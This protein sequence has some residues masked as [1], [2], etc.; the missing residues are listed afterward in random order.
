MKASLLALVLSLLFYCSYSEAYEQQYQVGGV[1]PNGGTVTAVSVVP[2]LTSTEE[3]MVGDFLETTYTYTYTETV[4][5]T[6]QETSYT[7]VTV[8]EEKTDSLIDTATITTTNTSTSCYD[9]SADYCTGSQSTGGGSIV[10]DMDVS[11]Y[12]NKKAIDY[13]STVTSHGSNAVLPPC[14][15]TTGDCQDE[16]KLTVTLMN[17]GVVEKTYVHHYASVNWSGSR[18]FAFNQDVSGVTFDTARLE[19]YGMDAGYYSGFY[20]PAFS[21]SF[22]DLT[23]DYIYQVIQQIVTDV[24][25]R[26]VFST[27]EYVYDSQYIPPPPDPIDTNPVDVVLDNNFDVTIETPDGGMISFEVNIEQ[28]EAGGFDVQVSE[29]EELPSLDSADPQEEPVIAEAEPAQEEQAESPNTEPT[30]TQETAEKEPETA[31]STEKQESRSSEIYNAVMETVKLAVMNQSEA[32]RGF[33]TYTTSFIPPASFYEP[34]ALDGGKNYDNPM[35]LWY[36]GAS[37]ALWNKMVRAQYE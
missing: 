1:G 27:D 37:D 32:A 16:F 22:F 35:G 29:I 23:Y 33:D 19:L 9:Q 34:V 3:Q 12:E 28:N 4:D 7:T 30:S 8:T 21:S 17:N 13:G 6:V 20:G 24:E 2:A 11:S 10:Y 36:S 14:S 31:A 15:Q 26:S 25:M 18:D 5:E